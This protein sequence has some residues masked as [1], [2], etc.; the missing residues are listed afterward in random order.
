MLAFIRFLS[1]FLGLMLITS[2]F[3]RAFL[4]RQ[5]RRAM[6]R[7]VAGDARAFRWCFGGRLQRTGPWGS[8]LGAM[9]YKCPLERR[10]MFTRCSRRCTTEV[11]AAA[12]KG[13]LRWLVKDFLVA[14]CTAA[15][16]RLAM[17]L[18]GRQ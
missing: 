7:A 17:L 15:V 14:A 1:Q 18:G 16:L 12:L 6:Q 3:L 10:A 8:M 11:V 5:A 4:L 2:S 13:A 9:A